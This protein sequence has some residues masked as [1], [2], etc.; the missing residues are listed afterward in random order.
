[1]T[2][3]HFC[4]CTYFLFNWIPGSKRKWC[5]TWYCEE[6]GVHRFYVLSTKSTGL[7]YGGSDKVKLNYDLG[8]ADLSYHLQNKRLK[9]SINIMV[10]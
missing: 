4:Y 10:F 5:W 6:K 7:Y 1:M 3:L 8:N 9:L 2:V